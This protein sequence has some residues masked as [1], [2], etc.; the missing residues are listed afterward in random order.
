VEVLTAPFAET[1]QAA[2]QLGGTLNDAFL[3]AAADA[4]GRYHTKLGAP[5]DELRASMAVS[6]R[7]AESGTNAF[8]IAR[9]S[10]PTGPMPIAERFRA[11]VEASRAS[12]GGGAPSLDSLAP[13]VGTLPTS[14][15]T[16]LARQATQAIDFATS[17]VRG[18]AV[19]M[20]IAGSRIQANYPIGP[21][22]GVSFNLT[23]VS[24]PGSL[25]M[26]V[27]IDP[28]AV[29]EPELLR[30]CLEA[31]FADL[32][33]AKQAPRRARSTRAKRR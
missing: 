5:V 24:L 4:A 17:N 15:I 14:V 13:V 1:K 2:K 20:Y 29:T 18:A 33:A 31:S 22:L 28:A 27:N 26:G 12:R 3:T 21:L 11:I 6:T 8:S 30:E 10:V 23:L 9:I 7:T 19:P 25:D 32:I 16:R